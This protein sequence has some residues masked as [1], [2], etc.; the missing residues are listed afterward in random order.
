MEPYPEGTPYKE[1]A[2]KIF[3][4][5]ILVFKDRERYGEFRLWTEKEV[6]NLKRLSLVNVIKCPVP[7]IFKTTSF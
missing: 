5:S 6:R 7:H 2:I 1:Y 3:K 4:T